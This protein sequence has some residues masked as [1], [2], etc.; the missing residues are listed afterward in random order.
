[1]A[2]HAKG[3]A[4]PQSNLLQRLTEA[5]KKAFDPASDEVSRKTGMADYS[6][7]IDK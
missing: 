3:A 5:G 7:I 1:M 4:A 6:E 2:D